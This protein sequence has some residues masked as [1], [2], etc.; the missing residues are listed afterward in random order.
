[1]TDAGM[2]PY[3]VYILT[4]R[5]GSLYT[6]IAKQPAKRLEQHNSGQGA[7]YTAGR[8]PC[9]LS[10]LE[11]P[12]PKSQALRREYR[13]KHLPRR[14]KLALIEAYNEKKEIFKGVCIMSSFARLAASRYSERRFDPHKMIDDEKLRLILE[15]AR[16]APTAH[17]F[18]PFHMTVMGPEKG[19]ERLP[20][21]TR[22][23]FSAPVH[24]LLSAV[25]DESWVRE[26][27]GFAAA[28]LDIGIVGAHIALQAE[29]LGIKSCFICAFNPELCR[30]RF[31]LPEGLRPIMIVALGYAGE[32]SKPAPAHT[33]RKEL[34]EICSVL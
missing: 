8:R 26:A 19:R 3:Y 18:Q 10:C 33:A 13:I 23:Y 24:I 28:E 30:E 32:H 31:E 22:S 25:D 27:D 21:V 4:C 34:E 2:E 1:M 7:K 15:A 5:D 20:E 9:R 29:D 6:G 11:G 16:C 17:N 12:Y 14:K